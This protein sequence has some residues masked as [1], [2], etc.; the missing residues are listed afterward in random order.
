LKVHTHDRQTSPEE[1]LAASVDRVP[2]DGPI[3]PTAPPDF[4]TVYTHHFAFA[5]RSLRLLGVAPASLE[6]AAQDVFGIVLRRLSELRGDASLKTWIF[7]IVQR[8][9]ANQRRSE[10]RKQRPLK[11]LLEEPLMSLDPSPEDHAEAAQAAARVQTFCDG[12]DEGH[13]AVFVLALIEDVPAREIA[14]ALGIPL[15]TVYSRVRSLREALKRFL[16]RNE[17][18]M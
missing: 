16:E 11:P 7:A 14:P 18:H 3:S 1:A 10:R 12:L 2:A 8:V 13:R 17:R 4:E 15:F 5:C 9:A 6:D